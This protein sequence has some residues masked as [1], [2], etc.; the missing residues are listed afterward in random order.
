MAGP[1]PSG[2]DRPSRFCSS[3][4]TDV[5]SNLSLGI[6]QLAHFAALRLL[7]FA[8]VALYLTGLPSLAQTTPE[9]NAPASSCAAELKAGVVVES[10]AKNSEGEKVGLVVGDI[11]LSCHRDGAK[12]QIS[13]PFDLAEV[14]TE[15]E[16]RGRVTLEGARGGA[17]REWIMGVESWGVR[18]RPDLPP[19]LLAI[20]REGQEL[21]DAGK[22]SAAAERWRAAAAESQNYKCQWLRSWILAH[23]AAAL[24]GAKEWKESDN[25]YREAIESVTEPDSRIRVYLLRAWASTFDQRS[26]LTNAEK[27]YRQAGVENQKLGPENLTTASNLHDLGRVL[28]EQGDL[29]KAE[30]CHREALEIRE[31]LAPGSREVAQSLNELAI[32]AVNRGNL[33]KAEDY[34]RRARDILEKILPDSIALALNFDNLGNVARERGDLAEADEYY[35]Q[36]LVIAVRLSPGSLEVASVLGNLGGLASDRGDLAVAEDYYQQS[37]TIRRKLAPGSLEEAYAVA[38]LGILEQHR[39]NLA[40]AEEYDQQSLTTYKK[41]AP[42]SLYTADWLTELGNIAQ[43]REDLNKAEEYYKQALAI[44]ERIAPESGAVAESLKGLGEIARDHKELAKAEEYTQQSLAI[45]EKSAP[46]GIG[47]ADC[48]DNLGRLAR[49]HQDMDSA[50]GFYRRAISI[51]KRLSPE[52]EPYAKSLAGLARTMLDK[53]QPEEAVRIYE[54]ALNV[55]DGQLGRLGGS[56]D[57]RAAYR[58]KHADYYLDYADLLVTQKKPELAFQVLE[59]SRAR[60]LL[61]LLVEAHVDI[62]QGAPPELLEQEHILQATLTAKS[63]RRINLLEGAHNDEQLA[64]VSKELAA[65]LEKYQ[66]VEAQIRSSSPAYAALTQPQ[67]LSA[68]EVQEQLLDSETVLLEYALGEKRS[69]VFL[70]TSGSLD[71]YELPKRSEVEERAHQVYDIL[72]S[73]NRWS[74]GE[75]STQRR[76]RLAK[77]EAGYQRAVATLSQMIL[78]PVAAGIKGKRLLI[79][80]DGALQYIPF[81]AL[82]V[83]GVDPSKPPAPLIA[84]HEIVNLPSAS[85]L[86]LLRQQ[87]NGRAA[88]PKDVAVFADPVF[89]VDDPRVKRAKL[90]AKSEIASEQAP[91]ASLPYRFTRSVG[92][93][94]GGTRG[95]GSGLPRLVFSRQ[96]A[97]AIMAVTDHEK[98]ME[99]LDFQANKDMALSKELGQ[100]RIVHFATHGLLDNDHPELS[101]LVLSLVDSRGKPQNGFLELQDVYNMNLPVDLVVLSACETGLG[102]EINGEGLVGITRGFMY[103]GAPRVVASLWKV[104]DAA[105]ADLMGRFYRAML[106]DGIRPAAALRQAQLEMW[107]DKRW[108]DPYNWAA[109]TIEGE[110]R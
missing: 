52:R 97:N 79:V 71:S 3:T 35:R 84:E 82:P 21:A 42:D 72:T 24:S 108:A 58:A 101:G 31:R 64:E 98:G 44:Q 76:A 17:K 56:S 60:T 92:D 99:A 10:V 62:H 86:A 57:V 1:F 80:A 49:D 107:K 32:V 45:Y 66:G 51:W 20:Y 36:S 59:R 5:R 83:P 95:T 30:K 28:R 77:D 11:I 38:N 73:R 22:F 39:G 78:G 96:E 91:A 69:H 2:V 8:A 110:W 48:L 7:Y 29:D 43:D 40:K 37:L 63:D 34:F 81:A 105:T 54:E 85:V 19:T 94:I 89:D 33:A 50:E 93:V 46:G 61:E 6:Y 87:T 103:A 9:A 70:V 68:R 25:L 100:Y 88:A 13:S 67:P 109:F 15:Q 104:D 4:A 65:A 102:K 18:T 16:P 53:Q 106:K 90:T 26:D 75:T 12:G 55:L 27:Y 74:E 41:L 47:I 14:L 23:A